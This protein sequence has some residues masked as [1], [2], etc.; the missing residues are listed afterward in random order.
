[1]ILLVRNLCY[2]FDAESMLTITGGA[3]CGSFVVFGVLA[4]VVYR[5]WRRRVDA[6]RNAMVGPPEEELET[7]LQMSRAAEEVHGEPVLIEAGS[8]TRE[9][10]QDRKG[11]RLV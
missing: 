8:P 10:Q 5:P 7:G 6:K 3:I 4:A 9:V 1:M 2:L 11:D